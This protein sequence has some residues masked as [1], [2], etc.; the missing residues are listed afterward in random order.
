V[1]D[2]SSPKSTLTAGQKCLIAGLLILQV[3]SSLIFYPVAALFSITGIGVPVSL[4][5][6]AIG[7]M[8]YSSAMRCKTAWQSG[9]GRKVGKD[10]PL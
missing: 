10:R 8:P 5:L 6:M 3:P 7:T 1:S 4:I 2:P 9:G